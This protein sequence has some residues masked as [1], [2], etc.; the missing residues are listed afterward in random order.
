MT[1]SSPPAALITSAPPP[2]SIVSFP[3]PPVMVSAAD[4]PVMVTPVISADASTS[5]K[6]ETLVESPMVWSAL[7]KLTFAVARSTSVLMPAPP[8][9]ETSDP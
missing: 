5:W 6:L 8:S 1:V 3:A 4:E 9:I 2:P 7:A